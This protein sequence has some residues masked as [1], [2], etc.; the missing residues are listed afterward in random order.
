MPFKTSF[1]NTSAKSAWGQWASFSLGLGKLEGYKGRVPKLSMN[2]VEAPQEQLD[3]TNVAMGVKAGFDSWAQDHDEKSAKDVEKYLSEHS[4]EELG[5]LMRERQIPFQDDPWAMAHFNKK[6][7]E[8]HSGIAEMQFQQKIQNGEYDNL[9]P[10]QLDA[11]HYDFKSAY[12]RGVQDN[13]NGFLDGYAEGSH[14]KE[15]YFALSPKQRLTA[16]GSQQKRQNDILVQKSELADL[17]KVNAYLSSGTATADGLIDILK[18]AQNTG[19]YHRT[20]DEV[21]KFVT[22]FTKRLPEMGTQGA[23]LIDE[24]RNRAIPGAGGLTLEQIYSKE[25]LD[26]LKVNALNNQYS[27]DLISKA[28]FERDMLRIARNGDGASEVTLKALL[29][30]EAKASG[31]KETWRSKVISQALKT[32]DAVRQ[33]NQAEAVAD[34]QRTQRNAQLGQWAKDALE[35]KPVEDYKAFLKK[36]GLKDTDTAAFWSN[37]IEG[38][39][40]SGDGASMQALLNFASLPKAPAKVTKGVSTYLSGIYN[41]GFSEAVESYRQGNGIPV[42][43]D[44]QTG[45]ELST[46]T[47][48][49]I[50]SGTPVDATVLP[51]DMRVLMDIFRSNPN[52]VKRIFSKGENS[53]IY[54]NLCLIDGAIRRKEN[55]VKF[56]GDLKEAESKMTKVQKDELKVDT[57]DSSNAYFKSGFGDITDI[58]GDTSA[59]TQGVYATR[60]KARAEELYKA[61]LGKRSFDDC[62]KDAKTEIASQYVILGNVTV[63]KSDISEVFLGDNKVFGENTDLDREISNRLGYLNGVIKKTLEEK[64]LTNTEDYIHSYYDERAREILLIDNN[65]QWRASISI[66]ALASQANTEYLADAKERMTK[67][68]RSFIDYGNLKLDF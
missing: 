3:W 44:P 25:G 13:S 49:P 32:L 24:L 30:R 50:G 51:K 10:E 45:N 11:A 20:P 33:K 2:S 28:N 14:F 8:I 47:Y 21:Y 56:M 26:T 1:G 58:T 6:M 7:G 57:V 4:T 27:S 64:N 60:V 63:P 48:V 18:D 22:G 15:G 37:I 12:L 68:N 29:E 42:A 65:F 40:A 67:G 62:F 31:G 53:K 41:Q 36:I 39:F 66:D 59:V 54:D 17:G 9:S 55:P 46:Y 52:A 5:Q 38:T 23:Q 16:I 19:G 34:A 35:G 43:V 61:N